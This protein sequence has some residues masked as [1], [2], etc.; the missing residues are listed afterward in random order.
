[1][2]SCGANG[3]DR[4]GQPALR[5]RGRPAYTETEFSIQPHMPN[6]LRCVDLEG[7]STLS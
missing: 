7:I 1:M 6:R 2:D 3:A 5:S 4:P